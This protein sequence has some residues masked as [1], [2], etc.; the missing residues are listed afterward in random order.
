[1][2]AQFKKGVLDLILL[3]TLKHQAKTTYDVLSELRDA[4]DVN[5]NTIYPLLR[6]LESDGYITHEK[7]QGEMGAPRKVYLLTEL[8]KEHLEKMYQDWTIFYTQVNHLLGGKNHE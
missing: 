8:G 1:M 2:N 4:M 6:R 3:Y 5:E 7:H